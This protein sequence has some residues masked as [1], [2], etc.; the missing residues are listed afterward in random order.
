MDFSNDILIV[1]IA[2][3]RDDDPEHG[4]TRMRD[5]HKVRMSSIHYIDSALSALQVQVPAATILKIADYSLQYNFPESEGQ[6][7]LR[8]TNLEP[9][10]KNY[11]KQ[12]VITSEN[13]K[14]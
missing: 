1:D 3:I 13:M 14:M 4:K 7:F 12:I 6:E 5:G 2:N 9:T 10:D 8:R 11:Y